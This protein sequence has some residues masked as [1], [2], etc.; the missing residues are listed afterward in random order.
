MIDRAG[1]LG[2]WVDVQGKETRWFPWVK[3]FE[4]ETGAEMAS[5]MVRDTTSEGSARHK[6]LVGS[7]N[8]AEEF[9]GNHMAT[10]NHRG[11]IGA[12]N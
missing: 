9:P 5:R 10:E 11:A 7:G 6:T 1:H 4:Q 3:E 12:A 8:R 2:A